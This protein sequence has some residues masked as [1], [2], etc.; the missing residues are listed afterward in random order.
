MERKEVTIATLMKPFGVKGEMRAYC[1]TS[2][3]KQR[4]V[5]GD[6]YHLVHPETHD[7][8]TLVLL[9]CR[10][11]G[12]E[13]ILRFEG[14]D[15]ME[16]AE[17]LRGYEVNIELSKAPLPKDN[18][19]IADL[20]GCAIIDEDGNQLGEVK[21]VFSYSPTWTLRVKRDKEKDFFVP[22]VGEFVLDVDVEAKR[23]KIRVMEGML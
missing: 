23:I 10:Q 21:D 6:S 4:F 8:K 3:P 5:K 2:Y 22:F 15:S 14:V 13:L 7:E 17:A 1:L 20:I 16:M 11:N 18:Y 19:R 12:K 9:S